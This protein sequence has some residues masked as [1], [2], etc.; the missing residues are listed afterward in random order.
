MEHANPI[1]EGCGSLR[2]GDATGGTDDG[3]VG[4]RTEQRLPIAVP[5]GLD[6]RFIKQSERF[7]SQRRI[8]I[9]T[10]LRATQHKPPDLVGSKKRHFDRAGAANR[11]PDQID[12]SV[13]SQV[14]YGACPL[15][16]V[17]PQGVQIR[18]DALVHQA[19][20][21]VGPARPVERERME[22]H[23]LHFAIVAPV[24]ARRGDVPRRRSGGSTGSAAQ[25]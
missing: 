5:R 10:R 13:A 22:Q 3:V 21:A 7:V 1:G 19:G 20:D 24:A 8:W 23:E 9:M 12:L 25:K 14:E 2:D 6:P 17:F 15:A 18:G 16:D 11:I 4:V